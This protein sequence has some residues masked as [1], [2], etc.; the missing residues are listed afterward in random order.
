MIDNGSIEGL[1][2]MD[3]SEARRKRCFA[4]LFLQ[5]SEIERLRLIIQSLSVTFPDRRDISAYVM[6]ELKIKT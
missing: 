5:V 6:N 1:C 4:K 2:A 3:Y